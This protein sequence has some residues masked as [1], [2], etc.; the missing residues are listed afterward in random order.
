MQFKKQP[1][2]GPV[3]SDATFDANRRSEQ[4]P[5]FRDGIIT[6]QSLEKARP[7]IIRPSKRYVPNAEP[8]GS[9][10]SEHSQI[11]TTF[12]SVFALKKNKQF[13]AEKPKIHIS[14]QTD[15]YIFTSYQKSLTVV[16]F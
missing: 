8:S 2:K 6:T 3:L 13:D 10:I 11:N 12:T 4:K 5:T 1:F 7:E 14:V 16:T 15:Q 9:L